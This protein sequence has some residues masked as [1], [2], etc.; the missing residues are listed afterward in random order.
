MTAN[1]E[2]VKGCGGLT[3]L[4]T[5][6]PRRLILGNW[7]SGAFHS[8]KLGFRFEVFSA[9]P[10]IDRVRLRASQAG[11]GDVAC[12]P[13]IPYAVLR[14]VVA[15]AARALPPPGPPPSRAYSRWPPQ[16]L[17]ASQGAPARAACGRRSLGGSLATAGTP[18]ILSA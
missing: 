9:L 4:F 5:E 10:A 15:S 12:D 13:R 1:Y 11:C 8:R 16:A 14:M 6:N 2:A 3:F 17:R 7:V 18:Y